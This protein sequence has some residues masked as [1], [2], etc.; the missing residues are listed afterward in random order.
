MSLLS[1]IIFEVAISV[2]STLLIPIEKK[3]DFLVVSRWMQNLLKLSI[4]TVLDSP[5]LWIRRNEEP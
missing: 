3:E 4:L 2:F 5:S 1:A